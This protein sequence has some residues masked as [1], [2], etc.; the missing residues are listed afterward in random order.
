M[1]K[2]MCK[3][4]ALIVTYALT[5]SILA[6]GAPPTHASNVAPFVESIRLITN[7]FIEINWATTD[8]IN[9]AGAS[10][11]NIFADN[12]DSFEIRLN[13]SVLPQRALPASM[14]NGNTSGPFYWNIVNLSLHGVRINQNKTTLQLQNALTNAQIAAI[15]DGESVL[16]V[17]IASDD[18]RSSRLN[19]KVPELAVKDATPMSGA[20]PPEAIGAPGSR[21]NTLM[22]HRV[23][24]EP[25]YTEAVMSLNGVSIRGSAEVFHA[26]VQDAAA[27][28]DAILSAAPEALIDRLTA[29]YSFSI[30]GP[31]EHPFNIPEHRSIFLR[32][33]WNQYEGYG[34]NVSSTSAA[35]VSRNHVLYSY[36]QLYPVRY[37][38]PNPN[39]SMLA[40][41]F[42]HAIMNAIDHVSLWNDGAMSNMRRELDAIRASVTAKLENPA[43]PVGRLK[44][45]GAESGTFTRMSGDSHGFMAGASTIWFNAKSES[46]W[47]TNGNG[48]VNTRDELRRYDSLTY[49]F[50]TRFM[51]EASTLSATWGRDVPDSRSPFFA[52]PPPEPSERFGASVKLKSPLATN[53]AGMGLQSYIPY[54]APANTIPNVE[55]WWDYD[56]DLMRWYLEPDAD[57][58]FFRIQRKNRDD[59][60]ENN[61][62]DDL[63][64]TP[65]A[66]VNGASVVLARRNDTNESQWW[67]FIQVSGGRFAIINKSNPDT[68]L[69][70]HDNTLIQGARLVLGE[71]SASTARWLIEGKSPL[72]DEQTCAGCGNL[73]GNCAC[74]R[75]DVCKDL[76]TDCVC[77]RCVR[78]DNP[79]V[80]C[81]CVI[82]VTRRTETAICETC[83]V[84]KTWYVTTM[85]I[86]VD[87]TSHSVTQRRVASKF[88]VICPGS[89]SMEIL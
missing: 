34:G 29:S 44:W 4:I 19:L 7:R 41:E 12:R 9:N 75:C 78:C 23:T 28:A 55:L 36:E 40:Y 87:G 63:V 89:G 15:R 31:G 22:W 81:L 47:Q 30:Y 85:T 46:A 84:W 49:N 16:E 57:E 82:S 60:T 20:I 43:N 27:Q 8:Y 39:E 2:R 17:R 62:R 71:T 18:V 14:A 10:K 48:P 70:L 77:I 72:T 32:D 38:T 52:P 13:G 65:T 35:N 68:A 26:T 58:R 74:P 11:E 6:D 64:L 50:L 76:L 86:H 59:Y 33:D 5:V 61:Q 88:G 1:T 25:Y 83:A 53:D 73:T 79:E 42:G 69:A 54:N 37:V 67:Q 66:A 21:A 24:Y 45:Q 3:L 80:I 56:T 51:P